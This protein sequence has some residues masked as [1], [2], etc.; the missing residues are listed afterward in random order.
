MGIYIYEIC[1]AYVSAFAV[2][3]SDLWVWGRA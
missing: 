1:R 2:R 3:V